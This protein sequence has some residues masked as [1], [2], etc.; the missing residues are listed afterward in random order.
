MG[1]VYSKG[2]G[3]ESARQKHRKEWQYGVGWKTTP[4]GSASLQAQIPHFHLWGCHVFR[5]LD[6]YSFTHY[7]SVCFSKA[8]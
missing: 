5:K 3:R 4:S 7:R 6:N 2:K 8:P 1:V